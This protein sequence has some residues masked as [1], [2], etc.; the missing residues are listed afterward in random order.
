MAGEPGF[1][2][3]ASEARSQRTRRILLR[4]KHSLQACVGCDGLQDRGVGCPRRLEYAG[5]RGLAE[6]AHVDARGHRRT[7]LH[8]RCGF[9]RRHADRAARTP[10]GDRAANAPRAVPAHAERRGVCPS[11]QAG[12]RVE[13]PLSIHASGT[14]AGGLRNGELVCLLPPEISFCERPDCGPAGKR[15]TIYS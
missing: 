11:G 10:A 15:Q 5:R 4:A 6:D 14:V 7:I 8:R 9:W 12:P 3:A 2:I 1:R 13:I